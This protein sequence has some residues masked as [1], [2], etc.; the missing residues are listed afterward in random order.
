MISHPDGVAQIDG[1]YSLLGYDPV[2]L[3]GINIPERIAIRVEDSCAP[4]H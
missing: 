3:I 4:F 1:E 2:Y